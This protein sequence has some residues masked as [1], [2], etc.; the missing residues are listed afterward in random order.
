MA[1]SITIDRVHIKEVLTA[2][3]QE[4]T[5]CRLEAVEGFCPDLTRDQVYLAIDYLTRAGLVC[6]TLDISG[7]YSVVSG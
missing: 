2:L 6:L 4:G 5:R 3:Q 7:T 1:M